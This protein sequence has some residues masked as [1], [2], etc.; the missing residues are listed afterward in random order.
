MPI[1]SYDVLTGR[2][3]V[4]GHEAVEELSD[5]ELEAEITIAALDA[6]RRSA[7]FDA[8]LIERTLRRDAGGP[9]ADPRCAGS[10]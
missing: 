9:R 6:R 7:R 10:P 4:G 1:E 5:A 8:L 3:M 2:P